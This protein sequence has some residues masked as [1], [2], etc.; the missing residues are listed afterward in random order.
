[1]N[2][3]VTEVVLPA[4]K[5][6]T[7]DV[8]LYNRFQLSV[9]FQLIL[10]RVLLTRCVCLCLIGVSFQPTGNFGVFVPEKITLKL[11]LFRLSFFSVV[12]QL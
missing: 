7:P 1:M 2:G 12:L 4:S 8:L 6:W 9:N 3:G 10:S 11:E 5:I